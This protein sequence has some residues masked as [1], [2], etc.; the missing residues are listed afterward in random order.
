MPFFSLSICTNNSKHEKN[1]LGK[2]AL[3]LTINSLC[4]LVMTFFLEIVFPTIIW[5][6]FPHCTYFYSTL[7]DNGN[8]KITHVDFP[9]KKYVVYT[10][11]RND[12]I[13]L[14]DITRK[15]I[16]LKKLFNTENIE[17]NNL[18]LYI[19]NYC[20]VS[21]SFKKFCLES[22]YIINKFA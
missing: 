12:S 13:L 21:N 16:T 22:K 3:T 8:Y 4:T 7:I 18:I 17:K 20:T 6:K 19:I 2:F 5:L 11:T 9:T 10:L 15:V 14:L 1:E